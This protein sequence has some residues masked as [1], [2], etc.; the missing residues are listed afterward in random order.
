[1]KASWVGKRYNS[2]EQSSTRDALRCQFIETALTLHK[3]LVE[4]K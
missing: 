2:E 4:E 1:M 3:M